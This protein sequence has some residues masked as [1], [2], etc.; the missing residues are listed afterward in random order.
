M[1]K[2]YPV[3][4]NEVDL[5][6]LFYLVWKGKIKIFVIIIFSVLASY[7]FNYSQP[8]VTYSYEFTLDIKP[9]ESIEFI[10]LEPILGFIEIYNS[11]TNEAIFDKFLKELM[12]YEELISILKDNKEIQKNISQLSERDRK[13]RLFDYAKLFSIELP[14]KEGSNHKLRFIWKD[15]K[16]SRDIIERTLK[17]SLINFQKRFIEELEQILE[18][19]KF[20]TINGDSERVEYLLEQKS[21]AQEL[22][23]PDNTVDSV[24]LSQSSVSFNFNANDVAYYLRGYKAIGKEISLIESREYNT[25]KK[26]KDQ[27]NSFK[28]LNIQWVDFNIFLLDKKLINEGNSIRINL[29]L[30]I[31]LGLIIGVFYVFLLNKFKSNKVT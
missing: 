14:I 28:E 15:K 8:K 18:M 11:K 10:K 6:E 4:D 30:S 7:L 1:K 19:R 26:I 5:K 3:E 2:I 22:D 16:E 31:I 24:N 27:L 25:F 29:I 13:Q 23:L 21:I 9:S 20:E 17:L 12:D